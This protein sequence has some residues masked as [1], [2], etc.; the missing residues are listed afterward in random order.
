M[1]P[2][3]RDLFDALAIEWPKCAACHARSS[4]RGMHF[5]HIVGGA[6]RK[7]DRRNLLRLCGDCHDT[8]H[9]GAPTGVPDL[10]KGMMLKL[11]QETD[12]KHFSP[13]WLAGLDRKRWL[14]YDPEPLPDWYLDQRRRNDG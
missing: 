10:T 4:W 9:M 1:R 8:L 13:E 5:H 7:H 12:L 14:G 11:K 2:A 6:G 3:E